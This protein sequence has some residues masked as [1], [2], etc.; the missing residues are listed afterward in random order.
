M[1]IDEFLEQRDKFWGELLNL[2]K[3]FIEEYAVYKTG[4]VLKV[5]IPIGNRQVVKHC[6]ITRVDCLTLSETLIRYSAVF[7]Y[8]EDGKWKKDFGIGSICRLDN[9]NGCPSYQ[10]FPIV[11]GYMMYPDELK[12][13]S[14]EVVGKF[15]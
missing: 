7:A 4:D 10:P 8:M 5:T 13:I 12:N 1:T 2:K 14:M 6:V 11:C 9:L 15:N 3:R